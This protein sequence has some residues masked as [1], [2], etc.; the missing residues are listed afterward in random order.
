MT[1]KK[2]RHSLITRLADLDESYVLKMVQRLL[3][4][5]ED[6]VHIIKACEQAMVIV[7][8]RYEKRQYYLWGLSWPA[9]SSEG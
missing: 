5:G 6:P 2:T 3:E 7:G 8:E 1:D 9:R 4:K